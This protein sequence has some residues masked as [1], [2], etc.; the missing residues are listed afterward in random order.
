MTAKQEVYKRFLEDALATAKEHKQ[1]VMLS[2]ET[3]QKII[4]ALGESSIDSRPRQMQ[5]TV[6]LNKF[7][8]YRFYEGDKGQVMIYEHVATGVK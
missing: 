5:H 6:T 7:G 2:Q 4:A 1:A 8:L 3:T